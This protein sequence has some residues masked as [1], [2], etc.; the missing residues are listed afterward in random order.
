MQVRTDE[1][2]IGALIAF[3]CLGALLGPLGAL[4][5]AFA[6]RGKTA[7]K[8]VPILSLRQ[9][10]ETVIPIA[11][12]AKNKEARQVITAWENQRP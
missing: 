4:V 7:L 2:D 8:R 9:D 10:E 1:Q 6:S 5:G 12:F 11:M 3:G